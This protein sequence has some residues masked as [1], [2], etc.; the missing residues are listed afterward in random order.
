MA[1][2]GGFIDL[3]FGFSKLFI[4]LSHK[5]GMLKLIAFVI[6]FSMFMVSTANA[7]TIQGIVYDLSLT[8]VEN[9]IVE[10]DSTPYQRLVA[11]DGSYSFN[12]PKGSYAIK[13]KADEDFAEENITITDEGIYNLDLFLFPALDEDLANDIDLETDYEQAK[14]LPYSMAILVILALAAIALLYRFRHKLAKKE[15]KETAKPEIKEL[16][17]DEKEK[18]LS[19]IKKQ[20]GRTTQ[21]DIRKETSLSEAKVS[22]ILA[23][24]EHEG[25]IKK[26]KKGRGNIIILASEKSP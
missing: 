6:A 21:K 2:K 23:E 18:I 12:L 19:I 16:V 22:L 26:I 4:I 13:A 8:P 5:K 17:P 11:K 3:L 10:V 1:G 24:L 20:G 7:A 25:K 9:S 14:R 15:Q